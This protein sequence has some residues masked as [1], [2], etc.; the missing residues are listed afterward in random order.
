MGDQRARSAT[1]WHLPR[2]GNA[3]HIIHMQNCI[4][5]A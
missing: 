5:G 4:L 1:E 2:I 3:I